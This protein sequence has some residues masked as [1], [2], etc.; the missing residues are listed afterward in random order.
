MPEIILERESFT[1]PLTNNTSLLVKGVQF[2][3]FVIY[4]RSV[5]PSGE[6]ISHWLKI[7]HLKTGILILCQQNIHDTQNIFLNNNQMFQVARLL[8]SRPFP[9][10][11]TFY[12]LVKN[13]KA[14]SIATHVM[15]MI[16]LVRDTFPN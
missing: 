13:N 3:K 9:D 7:A 11:D 12:D 15:G 10:A 5:N 2:G 1:L 6:E 14:Q 16:R 4:D 8:D